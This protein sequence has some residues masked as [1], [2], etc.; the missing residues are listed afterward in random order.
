MSS[1]RIFWQSVAVAALLWC[2]FIW[3]TAVVLYWSLPS[4]SLKSL[5]LLQG[6]FVHMK[7]KEFAVGAR[8]PSNSS[9]LV[10]V[11]V[12]LVFEGFE[13]SVSN[14]VRLIKNGAFWEPRDTQS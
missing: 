1:A 12:I 7:D 4:C 13:Q 11:K 3:S 9:P 14:D 6:V 2:R 8:F 10:R 5:Q